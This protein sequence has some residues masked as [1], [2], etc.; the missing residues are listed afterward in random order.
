M[1]P[2]VALAPSAF[3]ALAHGDLATVLDTRTELDYSREHVRGALAVPLGGAFGPWV[4]WIAPEDRPLALVVADVAA[5]RRAALELGAV[6]RDDVAGYV[7]DPHAAHLELAH[8]GRADPELLQADYDATVVDVRWDA[9]WEEGHIPYARHI[10]LPDLAARANEVPR[11]GRVAVHCRSGY[12][13]AI[14]V[15][16][17]ERAGVPNLA[18]LPG[19]IEAWGDAGGIVTS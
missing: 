6:G 4:A 12:R 3:A 15:S 1:P 5:A 18:H 14:G 13:S 7:T 9:E 19:G 11:G 10:P 16:L 8:V 2:P 17:L